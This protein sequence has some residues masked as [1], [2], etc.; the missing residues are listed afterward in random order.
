[1]SRDHGDPEAEYFYRQE[2]EKLAKLR[3]E[4][5]KERAAAEREARRQAFHHK[6][7][8]CGADMQTQVFKGV[9]IEVCPE[10]GAVLLDAGELESLAGQDAS[11]VFQTIGDL[12]SFSR[13]K[14]EG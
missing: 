9:E 14:R 10:C 13:R 6:C 12:F 2:Q 7:G 11:G 4:A 8:K 5:E 3:A 1:M